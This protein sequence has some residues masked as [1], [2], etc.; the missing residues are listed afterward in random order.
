MS[1]LAK[2]RLIHDPAM[3]R[4][5][6]PVYQREAPTYAAARSLQD[7]IQQ[8]DLYLERTDILSNAGA[9][10]SSIEWLHPEHT[11]GEW[12]DIE[13]EEAVERGFWTQEELDASEA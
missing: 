4:P 1:N 2:F 3:E 10:W 5:E 6:M 13:P 7:A 8:Y 11:F 12:A 9:S